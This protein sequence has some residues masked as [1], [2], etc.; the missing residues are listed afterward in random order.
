MPSENSVAY[1]KAYDPRSPKDANRHTNRIRG[2]R[3]LT[4][5]VPSPPHCDMDLGAQS[6]ARAAK[7]LI[8]SCFFF[9]PA[10]CWWARM[11][12]ESRIRS[13]VRIV[14]YRCEDAMHMPLALQR[15]KHVKA[16]VPHVH[17]FDDAHPIRRQGKACTHPQSGKAS[18]SQLM[19]AAMCA[20]T[21]P[22]EG[23]VTVI[24]ASK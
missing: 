18:G 9:A 3:R 8:L 4:A 15:P 16:A 11:M 19:S 7:V 24:P 21:L 23:M 5:D 22:Q 10:A 1:L 20:A 12:V 14:C 17:T 2:Y 6:A 13:K